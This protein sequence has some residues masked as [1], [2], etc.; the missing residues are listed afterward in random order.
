MGNPAEKHNPNEPESGYRIA[1][2][3][4]GP[5]PS[6]RIG[7]LGAG[8]AGLSAAHYLERAGYRHVTVLERSGRV[9][10]KCCTVHIDGRSYELGAALLSTRYSHVRALVREVGMHPVAK[11][12]GACLDLDTGEK[13]Y[14]VPGARDA[15]WLGVSVA[16]ARLAAEVSHHRRLARPGFAE[17]DAEL[18]TPFARW[19]EARGLSVAGKLV[20]PWFTT[21]GYGYMDEMPAAYVLKYLRLFGP[22]FELLDGGYEELWT[23][24]AQR[25]DVRRNVEV[26]AVHREDDGVVVDTSAGP[27]RFDALV[28]ACPIDDAVR[29][30]DATPDERDL[31]ARVRFHDYRVVVASVERFCD[32]RYLFFPRNF[33]SETRG[34]PMFAYRRWP[35]TDVQLFYA[36][37]DERMSNDDVASRV[38]A[39]VQA[40]GGEVT[41]VHR[42]QAWRYFPHVLEDDVRGGF[43]DDVEALQ[44]VRRTY[45]AGELM[46][47]GTVENVV[48]YSS[49]LV[50]RCFAE[51]REAKTG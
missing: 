30:L 27:M 33:G 46:S 6:W 29:L 14:R 24:V 32:S 40:R 25:L 48:A 42:V 1:T 23:R 36:F 9:G 7:V 16:C 18:A 34:E 20:E 19:A 13:T 5:Q 43:Y 39:A 10:G 26:R 41:R 28:V 21:F 47:F 50:G 37:A 12:S 44:G 22:L 8:P 4:G 31:F 49:A 51:A 3:R 17:V 2:G 45:Y 38:A 15:S 11:V 35:D